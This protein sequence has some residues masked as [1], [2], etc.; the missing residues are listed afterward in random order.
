MKTGAVYLIGAGPGDPDLLTVKAARLLASAEIVL[1]DDLVPEAILSLAGPRALRVSVGKRCGTKKITQAEINQ[2]IVE[3]ARQGLTVVRLKSGDPLVFG[4]A[5]EEMDALR[6]AGIA[7]EIVPGITAAFAAASAL[8][9]SLTDRRAAS[10]IVF[11]SGHHAPD[12]TAD[13][14]CD[15]AAATRIVYMPGRDFT[16]IASEWRAEGLPPEFPCIAISH[17]ARPDQQITVTTLAALATTEPGPAPVLLLAG[18]VFETIRSDAPGLQPL[19][20]SALAELE[21]AHQTGLLP[22]ESPAK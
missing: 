9:C 17:A 1:H 16:A 8:Q 5:A 14:I 21:V 2:L 11:R 4:R 15:P 13:H 6:T 10:G 20:R 19:V 18:W 3:K 22:V 12:A 7:F